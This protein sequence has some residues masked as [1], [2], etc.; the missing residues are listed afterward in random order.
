MIQKQAG[1]RKKSSR[2]KEKLRGEE[3]N[4]KVALMILM[5]FIH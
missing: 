5:Y 2:I 3:V 4:L 1:E